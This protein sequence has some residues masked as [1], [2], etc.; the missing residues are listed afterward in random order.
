MWFYIVAIIIVIASLSGIGVI[1][2]KKFPQ[3]TLIDT[4]ALPLERDAK[5][6]KEI[7]HERVSRMTGSFGRRLSGGLT[8]GFNRVQERFRESYRKLL[9]LEQRYRT[10]KPLTPEENAAKIASLFV[11]A[12]EF[13]KAAEYGNAEKRYIEVLSID[14]KNHDAYWGLGELY[15]EAKRYDQ[16]KETFAYLVRMLRKTARCTHGEAGAAPAD[17]PCEA[18]A[19]AHSDIATGWFETGMAAQ[20]AGDLHEAR[21]AFERSVAFEP[22]NPRHLDLLLDA[23]ILE[24][25]KLRAAEVLQQLRAANPENNKL[26]AF[27]ER[28]AVLSDPVSVA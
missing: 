11:Q 2:G 22:A 17:R 7:M 19:S 21:K 4:E 18:S 3:L 13:R 27:A 9:V 5:K 16:A 26:E 28:V 1:V 25:D 14:R 23:C 24:G 10:Q 20:A 6:K 8:R 15:L 12:V